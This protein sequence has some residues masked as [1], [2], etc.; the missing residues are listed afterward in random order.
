MRSNIAQNSD[1]KLPYCSA[2]DASVVTYVEK[3]IRCLVVTWNLQ[4]VVATDIDCR[5]SLQQI[6]RDAPM[7]DIVVIGFQEMVELKV[8]RFFSMFGLGDRATEWEAVLGKITRKPF[9]QKYSMISLA[10]YILSDIEWTVKFHPVPT[11]AMGMFGTKGAICGFVYLTDGDRDTATIC[12][13]NAHLSSGDS[14]DE[15]E[16]RRLEAMEILRRGAMGEPVLKHCDMVILFGDLNMRIAPRLEAIKAARMVMNGELEELLKLDEFMWQK[17][18]KAEPYIY[19]NEPPIGFPPTYKYDGPILS[20]KRVAGYT[21]RV[22][23]MHSTVRVGTLEI[24]SYVADM[25]STLSDHK[26]VIFESKIQVGYEDEKKVRNIHR[27]AL[28]KKDSV[29][30]LG[31]PRV[32]VQPTMVNLE[33]GWKSFSLELTGTAKSVS[34]RVHHIPSLI[35]VKGHPVVFDMDNEGTVEIWSGRIRTV[36]FEPALLDDPDTSRDE[37]III[38]AH[39]GNSVFVTLTVA[40]GAS[41][42]P[43]E[44]PTKRKQSLESPVEF[45]RM[46]DADSDHD[47]RHSEPMDSDNDYHNH[48]AEA[49]WWGADDVHA[50]EGALL[51]PLL[52][53][54]EL[55]Y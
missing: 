3:D 37:V 53:E 47:G 45:I 18:R 21:D 20:V 48:D 13:I 10:L 12:F 43:M 55:F 30:N 38:Q 32:F 19:F 34:I 7:Y 44:R 25:T 26:P 8:G 11:A 23:Y 24:L 5:S 39:D 2:V 33:P 9:C 36:E 16:K 4:G 29:E 50:Q 40:P 46:D 31:R 52:G 42:I 35:K 22:W 54:K 51:I 27:N 15:P 6:L 17:K 1:T 14:E 28:R 41:S 49:D